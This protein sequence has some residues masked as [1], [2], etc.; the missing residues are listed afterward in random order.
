MF[1]V[2]NATLGGAPG[3]YPIV[4]AHPMQL[5]AYLEAIWNAYRGAPLTPSA[6]V[7][8]YDGLA[9]AG[10]L[11]S[12]VPGGGAT[13]FSQA[14]TAAVN[15]LIVGPGRTPTTPWRHLIYAYL[16]ETTGAYE[17]VA[18]LLKDAVYDETLGPLS[19]RTHR[20]LRLTEDLFFRDGNGS[21]VSTLTSRVRPDD[22]LIRRNAYTRLLG[23]PLGFGADKAT[24]DPTPTAVN[25][26]FV[27]TLENLLRQLWGGY[28][29][30]RNTTGANTTDQNQMIELIDRLRIML[31]RR[32]DP[33][34]VSLAR[35][36]FV[37]VATMS[38]ID[39]TFSADTPVVQDLRAIGASP[40]IRL[41]RVAERAGTRYHANARNFFALANGVTSFQN[42]GAPVVEPGALPELLREIEQGIWTPA[43][44]GALYLPAS[45][46]GFPVPPPGPP[47]DAWHQRTLEIINHWA[48]VTGREL[49]AA[50]VAGPR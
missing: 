1:K 33:N 26:D 29:N 34:G 46:P 43:N 11:D 15:D 3:N 21:L 39:F 4:D 22:G 9:L 30:A 28:T 42:P 24:N 37:A 16:I 19:E 5:S 38:W 10:S 36:E 45:A 14:A 49:K 40:D 20:W 47:P 48:I 25:S 32:R 31:N 44:I 7:L 27:S 8:P 12:L 18:K 41:Q 35:E 17:V 13:P 23:V 2:L 50:P 6:A